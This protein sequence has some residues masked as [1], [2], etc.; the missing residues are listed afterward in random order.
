MTPGRGHGTETHPLNGGRDGHRSIRSLTVNW[1]YLGCS[2]GTHTTVQ[3]T[4]VE[5]VE[6][7]EEVVEV[8]KVM[9][10]GGVRV[11]GCSLRTLHCLTSM[12]FLKG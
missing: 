3:P 2:G 1:A 11:E 4:V 8:E 10:V 7:V 5:G 9:I 6:E 12:P